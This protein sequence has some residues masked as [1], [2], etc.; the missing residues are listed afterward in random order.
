MS[1]VQDDLTALREA[2]GRRAWGDL[3]THLTRLYLA[4]DFYAGLEI[5]VTR[6]HDY[7]PMFEGAHPEAVWARK[8]LVG[9]VAY[10]AAPTE[11]P[12]EAGQ[13][14]NSP[15]SANFLNG[16]FELCRAVERKTPLENR[17]RFAASALCHVM[18]A[19]L[20]AFWYGQYPDSWERQQREGDMVDAE[21]GLTVRQQ[22]YAQFWL[23]ETV[24]ARDTAAWLAAVDAIEKKL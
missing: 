17:I 14:Y 20:A 7:L 19:E 5:A 6:A 2:A 10:G 21:T 4:L 22:I 15:G 12:P 16:L 11:L 8:L 9:I 23:D 13:A 18:L 24:A 3:Q 1:D